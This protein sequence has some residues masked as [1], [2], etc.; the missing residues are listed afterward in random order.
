M[1]FGRKDKIVVAITKRFE[2]GPI[3]S[4]VSA[5]P[6]IFSMTN[7][8]LART[9]SRSEPRVGFRLATGEFGNYWCM[10]VK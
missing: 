3:K 8:R 5:F 1:L 4:R 2:R 9:K 6:D 7:F 10:F